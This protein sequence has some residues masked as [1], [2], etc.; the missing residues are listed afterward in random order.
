MGVLG[1]LLRQL[2]ELVPLPVLVAIIAALVYFGGP[3]WLYN[4][5]AQQMRSQV[6]RIVRASTAEARQRE[7]DAAFSMVGRRPRLLIALT[8]SAF[9][10]GQRRLGEQALKALEASGKFP[11]DTERLRRQFSPASP[12]PPH[13]IE[14]AANIRRL[15][16]AGLYDSART[17]LEAALARFPEDETLLKFQR[18]FDRAVELARADAAR[19]ESNVL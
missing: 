11:K 10:F 5:H 6:R 18:R 2:G 1:T 7:E 8:E 15:F 9:Q 16:A 13:P 17:Q 19:G 4:V 14:A 12:V 3:G